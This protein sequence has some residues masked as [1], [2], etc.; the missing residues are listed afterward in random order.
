MVMHYDFKGWSLL[1]SDTPGA[2][3]DNG[4]DS[5]HETLVYPSGHMLYSGQ[6]TQ[7]DPS[8]SVVRRQNG[9]TDWKWIL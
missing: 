1:T 8:F 2:I 3:S 6:H 4:V 7:L 5:Y 9:K